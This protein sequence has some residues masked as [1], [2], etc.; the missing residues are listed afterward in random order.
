M[1][2]VIQITTIGSDA[3]NFYLFSDVNGFTS[4]F[5]VGVSA[6]ELIAGYATDQIPNGTTVV[7]ALSDA[8]C[9]S[10]IDIPITAKATTT[11]TTTIVV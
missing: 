2:G 1:T 8:P 3:D 4:A 5:A 11:T 6:A 9:N 10:Y 7:R